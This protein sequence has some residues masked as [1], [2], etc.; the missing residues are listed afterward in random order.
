VKI[1]AVNGSLVSGGNVG[2]LLD[3]ALSEY[4]GRSDV[5]VTRF[6]LSSMEIGPCRHCNWCINKQK[7]G[8][9]CAE[10]DDMWG[11][12][13][14][15]VEA[16]GIIIA[17]PVHFGRLSG[18]TADF[19]DRLRV[20]VHGNVAR[21][22]MRN[23]VGGALA[24]AWFRNAGVETALISITAAFNALGMVVATP[25]LGVWGGGAFSS[26]EGTGRTVEG[27]KVL[28]IEDEPGMASAR[29][30]ASRVAELAA[31]LEAGN[32]SLEGK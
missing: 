24:V 23:K 30:T 14:T 27:Q 31:L 13:P 1:V 12:Y 6:E 21:G 3:H 22:A 17:T 9:F 5:E 7:Q 26:L 19:I 15:L 29:S 4:D 32:I 28:V 25:D 10:K 2:A 8:R 16:D 20:F 11:V 18:A